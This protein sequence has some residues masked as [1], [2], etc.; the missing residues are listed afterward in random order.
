MN[1]QDSNRDVQ[2]KRDAG[3]V[4][5]HL[6]EFIDSS[7]DREVVTAVSVG[8][9]L[10]VDL[11]SIGV[12]EY[13]FSGKIAPDWW[14]SIEVNEKPD[15]NNR[16]MF[17]FNPDDSAPKNVRMDD[18]CQIDFEQFSEKLEKMGFTRQH[19][20]GEHGRLMKDWFD[21][22][23]MRVEVYPEGELDVPEGKV[24]RACV[25]WVFIR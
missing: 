10:G 13:I 15:A 16:L 5:S 21:R 6:L 20:H 1:S 25:K 18:V 14:Y 12:G 4:L 23:G 22:P 11:R 8:K 17:M 3:Q 9:G 2:E 24:G 7:R 19:Y